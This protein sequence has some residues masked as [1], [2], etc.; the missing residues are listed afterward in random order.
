MEQTRLLLA[1]VLSFLVFFLWN[2]FFMEEKPA[3]KKDD[4]TAQIEA[5]ATKTP[6]VPKS[7]KTEPAEPA[8]KPTPTL[9]Q[10]TVLEENQAR[11]IQ[12]VTPFYTALVSE[13]GAVFKGMILS[14]YKESM[15]E[16]APYLDMINSEINPGSLRIGFGDEILKKGS[17]AI[18]RAD[19]ATDRV[20]IN[21]RPQQIVFS[22][23]A[24]Q[25][26][27]VE[28]RFTFSPETYLIGLDV[29]I[30]NGSD[31]VLKEY[32]SL[33]LTKFAPKNKMMYGFEGPSALLGEKL[34]QV[35][36]DDI[37]E[38]NLLKGLIG[39]I[40]VQDRYFISSII[41]NEAIETSFKLGLG[42]D[43][44]LENRY[45]QPLNVIGPGEEKSFGY[46]IFFGPK[47]LELLKSFK[48]GLDSAI[49]FGW[50]D[51]IAKPCVWIMNF[52]YRYIPNYG[53]AIILMTL[54]I[55]I[56]LWPLG[57]KSYRSMAEMK[58]I[59]PLVAELREKHQNDKKKM[60][61]EMM[62][63]YRVYK[64][65]PLGGC[66][67]MVLQIPV[68]FALY[69]ML[70]ET[71]ELRHAPFFGWIND[72]SAPD[73]LFDFGFAIPFMEPPYGIPVLTIVMGASMILQ[74][75][76]SPP[77]GDPT[78]AKMMMLMPIIFTVIFIN[79]SS[80]LVLYWLVSNII[81]IAQQ[82]YIGKKA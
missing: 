64:V 37:E 4:R 75:K 59:Q 17:T 7:E 72:L 61:E 53:I 36:L 60:N 19:V 29:N 48:L 44:L 28:K 9:P 65:N 81:S 3:S 42:S 54:L 13:K 46:Q 25:G 63:L 33:S 20:E 41:P 6:F 12:I 27:L 21:D 40:A 67:P 30:R 15:A 66:L 73:R 38:S 50:F 47:S 80:G 79:F 49:D 58:K 32:I 43:R 34:Q 18:F 51:F 74:Q 2:V 16:N 70:Y 56:L 71:I 11:T 35:E 78:Q 24:N 55:K 69:R 8:F 26:I 5:P 76:M 1:I 77:P 57:N 14:N 39:W 52:F 10:P 62:K 31:K 22:W 23:Q 45:F 68:F 82:Y